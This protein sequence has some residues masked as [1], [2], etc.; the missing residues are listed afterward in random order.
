[1]SNDIFYHIGLYQVHLTTDMIQNLVMIG[2][3]YV[4][5]SIIIIN[6]KVN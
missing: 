1:M 3:D 5:K 2:T 4:H 6:G